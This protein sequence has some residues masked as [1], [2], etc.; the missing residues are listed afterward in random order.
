MSADEPQVQQEVAPQGDAYVAARDIHIHQATAPA[1]AVRHRVWGNV[2]PRNPGFTGR[3]ELLREVRGALIAGDRAVVQA[4]HGM[5]GVGKTQLAI[6]YAHKHADSYDVVWWISA[7]QPALIAEQ[8]AALAAKL[9]CA[10]P[11]ADLAVVRQAVLEDLRERGGWLLV[12]D[13]AERPED[14]AAWLPD[15]G[16]RVLIT[17]RAHGWHEIA[18]SVDVDVLDRTESVAILRK[19]VR[20]MPE[21]DADRVAAAVGDLPLALAQAASYL[22]DTGMPVTEYA[23]LLA[24]R[25]AEILDQGRPS[26]YPR[27]LAAVTQL[28]FERLRDEDPAAA[29]LAG[30]CAFLA[31]EPI[32]AQWF[33]EA[34]EELPDRIREPAADPVTWRGML[35]QL[36]RSALARIGPDGLVMHRLTQAILR[37]SQP[38]G[39]AE[40]ARDLAGRVLKG[41]YPGDPNTPGSWPAWARVLPH[42]LA[43]DP[44]TS[45]STDIRDMATNAAWYLLVRGDARGTHELAGHL[46]NEWR[47]LG[48]DDRRTLASANTLALALSDMGRYAEAR[49]VCEDIHSRHRRLYGDEHPRTFV[50]ATNLASVLYKLG[51][52]QAACE[53]AEETLARRRRLLGEDHPDTLTSAQ[54]L[55]VYLLSRGDHQ[56]AR[57][58]DE[59]TLARQRRV[60]GGDHPQ[61]LNTANNLV[62]D[63]HELGEHRAARELAE[64]TLA[65][66][67]QVLGEDH[68]YTLMSAHNLAAILYTLGDYHAARELL[69]DAL[70]RR[71]RVLGENHPYTQRSVD[72]LAEVMRAVEAPLPGSDGGGQ[73][74]SRDRSG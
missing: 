48:P 2:P 65:R 16:G 52:Y 40:A 1:P 47:I 5:G 55:G 33:T 45:G 72:K 20:G 7:E 23:D 32:P 71:R 44:A 17:S 74:D 19:R 66:Q 14:I 38:P 43:L 24:D 12:F 27:S 73:G 61:T 28:A 26:S 67:R 68:P 60:R 54:G 64:Q 57:A 9:G 35:G 41:N 50:T 42:L 59:D 10:S 34:T 18:E 6:E 62:A 37:G 22:A 25:A 51:D 58:L 36:G 69:T 70:A 31:P 8:F 30:I 29:D 46:Y 56:A 21:A 39:Q 13:N 3:K 63:L 15:G 49:Q 53:L 11:G 4:L